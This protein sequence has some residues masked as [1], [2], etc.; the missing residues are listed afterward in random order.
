MDK[1]KEKK[2]SPLGF[3]NASFMVMSYN[4]HIKSEMSEEFEKK[5][6]AEFELAEEKFRKQL[7]FELENMKQEFVFKIKKEIQQSHNEIYEKLLEKIR[8]RDDGW[9]KL[10]H[11]AS[12]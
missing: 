2:I 10:D 7:E 12:K 4:A 5:L 6:K 9:E 1:K 8:H 3:N 11:D